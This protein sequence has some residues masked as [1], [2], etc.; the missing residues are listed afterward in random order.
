MDNLL[1][2]DASARRRSL[3]RD[4]S[5]AFASAW[6]S[7]HPNGVYTYRDLAK[8]PTPFIDEAWTELCD[9]VL[10][11]PPTDLERIADLART[12]AQQAAWRVVWPLL[13]EL[14]AADVI[15]IGTPMYNYSIPATLKA[16]LDQ[17]TFP[18]M[19]L[20][21]RRFVVATARGGAYSEGAPKAAFDYQKRYLRDFFAGHFAV[22]ETVF[23][24]AEL[25]NARV[26]PSL[27]HL[28]DEHERSLAAAMEAAHR[29]GKEL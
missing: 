5:G 29:L 25:A 3:S 27:A 1:H 12:P 16:W 23:V 4:L 6:R 19:S 8:N 22:S 7:Q 18:R 26:D 17:V 21:P 2:L 20:A 13:A 9:A 24:T 14:L 11:H 15:L 10:S 28:R